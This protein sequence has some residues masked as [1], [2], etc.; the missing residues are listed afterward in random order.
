MVTSGRSNTEAHLTALREEREL[1]RGIHDALKELR[2]E[3]A[4]TVHVDFE[5]KEA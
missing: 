1:T 3:E 2:R 5:K 4:E